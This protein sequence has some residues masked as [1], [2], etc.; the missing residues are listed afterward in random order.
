MD[1][2][3][4]RTRMIGEKFMDYEMEGVRCRGGPKKTQREVVKKD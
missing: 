3:H 1:M 4:E 2:C